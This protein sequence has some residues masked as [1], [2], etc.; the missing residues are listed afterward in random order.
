MDHTHTQQ[1]EAIA[2]LIAW[3]ILVCFYFLPTI[4]AAARGHHNQNAVAAVN[5]F[6][7]WTFLGWIIAFVWSLTNEKPQPQ[8]TI[9]YRDLRHKPLENGDSNI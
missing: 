5:F 3:A 7:G 2:T 6:L 1:T 4:I 8:Q 9:I